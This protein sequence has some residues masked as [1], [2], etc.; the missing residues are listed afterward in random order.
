M[1]KPMTSQRGRRLTPLDVAEIWFGTRSPSA[2]QLRKVL[3]RMQSGALALTDASAPPARWTTTE[4]ALATFLAARRASKDAVRRGNGAA[5][6]SASDPVPTTL[7]DA[8]LL[9]HK[10]SMLRG[11]YRNVWSDYFLAVMIRRRVPHASRAFG[12]A[13]IAG[14]LI[15]VA[16]IAFMVVEATGAWAPG[17]PIE[18]QLVDDHLTTQHDWHQVEQWHPPEKDN[19]GRQV[20]RVE[21]RYRDG[22]SSRVVSTDRR[23]TVGTD[24]VTEVFSE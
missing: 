5:G 23:F 17:R 14:Q 13:V 16:I 21:Y 1:V 3:A 2:D 19:E 22:D 15:V 7:A 8:H 18:Q 6:P 9:H 11:A 4:Q 12:R 10:N 24:H 20:V